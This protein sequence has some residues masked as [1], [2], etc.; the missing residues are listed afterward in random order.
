MVAS[1]QFEYPEERR[2]TDDPERNGELIKSVVGRDALAA[3][4]GIC[5]APTP[6]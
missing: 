3:S 4:G 6:I 2:L 1:M 5:A